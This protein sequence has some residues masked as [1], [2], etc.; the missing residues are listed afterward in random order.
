VNPFEGILSPTW[1][2]TLD[3]G[4]VRARSWDG[5]CTYVPFTEIDD[6]RV[7]FKAFG[8]AL[9]RLV[10][11]DTVSTLRLAH[12]EALFV[13]ASLLPHVGMKASVP[14]IASLLARNGR[15]VDVW[16]AD[17]RARVQTDGYREAAMDSAALVAV[18]DD[19]RVAPDVRAAA[20]H[21]LLHGRREDDVVAVVRAFVRHA[22]PP[23]VVVATAL[24]PGGAALVPEGMWDDALLYLARDEIEGAEHA[25]NYSVMHANE[26]HLHDLLERAK[27]DELAAATAKRAA[28]TRH[29]SVKRKHHASALDGYAASQG[30]TRFK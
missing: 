12:D 4:G 21:A 27:A 17:V 28:E 15:P 20:S 24:A 18:L 26:P 30:V 8:I 16:L 13:Q 6:A 23:I 9:L 2:I 22:L 5:P 14:A 1:V 7:D 25:Q 11:R 19:A 29:E 10:K 3:D